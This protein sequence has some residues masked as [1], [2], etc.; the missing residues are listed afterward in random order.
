MVTADHDRQLCRDSARPAAADRRRRPDDAAA[1]RAA[2]DRYPD[3]QLTYLVEPAAAPIVR[4]NPHIHNVVVVPKRRGL[5]RLARR[6]RRLRGGCGASGSTSR[7]ICTAGPR[8]AWFTWASGAPMRIGY[9][10]AGRSWMYTHV[11]A[12]PADEAPRHS[13]VNQWDLLAPLDVGP[14]G[15]GA[16]SARD[17]RGR[18]GGRIGRTAASRGRHRRRAPARRRARQRREPVP[19]M[20]ARVVRGAGRSR[21]RGAIRRGGSFSRRA[22]PTPPAAQAIADGARAALGALGRRRPRSGRIRPRRTARAGRA[23]RGVHWWR[24]RATAHRGNDDDADRGA[25]RT[26]AA[27]AIDAVARSAVV[28]RSGRRGTARVPAVPAARVRAGRL[29]LPDATSRPSRW[30]AAAERA[31]ASADH[32]GDSSHMTTAD[33]EHDASA[34]GAGARAGDRCAAALLRRVAADLDRRRQHPARA[35]DGLLDR[36]ARPREDGCRRCRAS[37]GRCVAYAAVTLV[38]SAFSLDPRTS[39]IDDKQLVLFVIV[40]AVY[41]IARGERARAGRRRHRVGRRRQRGL[42]HHPVRAAA[43]RQPRPPARRR[44]VALHDLLGPADAGHLR[45]G[46]A[47]DLRP[48]RPHVARARDAGARRRPRAHARTQRV[49]RRVAWPSRCCWRSRTSDSPSLLP[50]FIALAVCDRAGN[51]HQARDVDLRRAGADQPGSA[52]DDR[53]RRAD[54]QGPPADRRR[55]RT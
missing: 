17:G 14:A 48:A 52:R 33:D 40:P 6:S 13:V 20:A 2:A 25:A 36:A 28:C 24:Q 19:P 39:L 31:M 53:D 49:D 38:V 21:W 15:S 26:D 35:D 30:S 54:R 8:G 45:G 32:E 41:H 55:A 23:R 9:A 43:L 3:A 29:P 34:H 4:G 47:A 16:R 10:I 22:R 46:G 50:V 1:A 51:R 37:S 44:D 18:A 42:R 27:G 5:A 11:I 7:S 12:R